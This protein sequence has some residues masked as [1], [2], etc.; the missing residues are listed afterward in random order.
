VGL[1][2]LAGD[3]VIEEELRTMMPYP[4]V[5]LHSTRL[6]YGGDL[7]ERTVSRLEEQ[8]FAAIPLLVPGERLDVV[9]FGCTSGA[10]ALG[11]ER[12][13]GLIRRA[14]PSAACIDPV[15]AALR[16]LAVLGLRRIGLLTPYAAHVNAAMHEFLSSRGLDVRA[17]RTF[18]APVTARLGRT[19]PT[20][21]PPEA[22]REAAA[23][24]GRTGDVDGVFISCTGLR[25]AGVLEEIE[26]DTGKPVISSNQAL[27]WWCLR[28]A[29]I[30]ASIP[31]FGRLL[32]S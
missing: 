26:R 1:L 7:S 19:P 13:H 14:R 21:V 22:I 9:V 18:R 25:C 24:L 6:A 15:T 2:A 5:R 29:G 3:S 11:V 27:S 20:R 23:A 32:R 30:D 8:I 28:N 16:A 4:R 12:L 10:V 31:G 17:R